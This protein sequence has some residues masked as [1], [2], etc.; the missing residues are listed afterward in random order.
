M[1]TIMVSLEEANQY[2]F[3]LDRK[4]EKFSERYREYK[5]VDAQWVL[6]GSYESIDG[7]WFFF[8]SDGGRVG[9]G[10]TDSMLVAQLDSTSEI[11]LQVESNEL[12]VNLYPELLPKSDR[13]RDPE[14]SV[15]TGVPQGVTPDQIPLVQGVAG[16][17]L[18]P[19]VLAAI[20]GILWFIFPESD[21]GNR[22]I[23]VIILLFLGLVSISRNRFAKRR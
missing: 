15:G 3:N 14:V 8:P 5:L 10:I 22:L 7:R 12:W 13:P 17:I 16:L 20:M 4:L 2:L 21:F 19:S 18:I 23:S 6:V 1:K 11:V 9:M